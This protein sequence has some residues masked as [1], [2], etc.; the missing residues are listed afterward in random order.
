MRAAGPYVDDVMRSE[1]AFLLYGGMGTAAYLTSDGRVLH[2]HRGWDDA[3]PPVREASEDDAI[4]AIVA[5]ARRTG[6]HALLDLL[7]SPPAGSSA[8]AECAG[9]RWVTL[10]VGEFVCT[11]CAGRGFAP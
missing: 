9:T 7:P 3:V 1:D 10:P 4:A 5:G 6:I 2:D 11:R 8:C